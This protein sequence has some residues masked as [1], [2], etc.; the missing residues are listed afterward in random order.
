[1]KGRV[2]ACK[3]YGKPFEID[4]YDVP[5]CLRHTIRQPSVKSKGIRAGVLGKWLPIGRFPSAK[6]GI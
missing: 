6:A 3:E 2:V 1:M 4:E 5:A